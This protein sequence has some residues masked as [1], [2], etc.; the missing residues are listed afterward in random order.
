M[1]H[2]LYSFGISMELTNNRSGAESCSGDGLS[3]VRCLL[4]R[5]FWPFALIF[6]FLYLS[7]LLPLV[8]LSRRYFEC[9]RY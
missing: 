5:C 2:A 1:R 3:T 9:S 7:P 4:N 6:C 8:F